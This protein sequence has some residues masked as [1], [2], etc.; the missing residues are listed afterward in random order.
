MRP[1]SETANSTRSLRPPPISIRCA[2]RSRRTRTHAMQPMTSPAIPASTPRT[3]ISAATFPETCTGRYGQRE[4]DLVLGGV[5]GLLDL[6][7]HRLHV[8][9]H[10]RPPR[11]LH[12]AEPLEGH[13][14]ALV[15]VDDRDLLV[16]TIGLPVP[17]S[18]VSVTSIPTSCAWPESGTVTSNDS[19]VV[20]VTV[21]SCARRERLVARLRLHGLDVR[22][23]Q[24]R[25]AAAGRVG[26]DPLQH[27]LHPG[28]PS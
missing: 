18:I 22:A 13:R 19:S 1:W 20:A 24:S 27:E 17:W 14:H 9:L 6:A 2:S 25:A 10:R 12:L 5:V 15:R 3:A 8:D 21:L 16:F 23:V 26:A 7:R 11:E 4:D 28:A